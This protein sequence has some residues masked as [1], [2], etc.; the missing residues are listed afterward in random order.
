VEVAGGCATTTKAA[1]ALAVAACGA[2]FTACGKKLI[3]KTT[4]ARAAAATIQVA[5][6]PRRWRGGAP[7]AV[8]SACGA[9][10]VCAGRREPTG[11]IGASSAVS[12]KSITMAGQR[13]SATEIRGTAAK[14]AANCSPIVSGA[15]AA[16]AMVTIGTPVMP[17]LARSVP[18]AF[19]AWGSPMPQS[20]RLTL[21]RLLR[22]RNLRNEQVWTVAVAERTRVVVGLALKRKPSA[23]KNLAALPQLWVVGNTASMPLAVHRMISGVP[24]N[25][26][27]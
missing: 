17:T 22:C 20:R 25:S 13:G 14:A 9:A 7:S 12:N 3:S 10:T 16:T 18:S 11:A 27:V 4:A 2:T 23:R 5:A 1:A 6:E 24:R 26:R 15:L 8:S 21:G 19:G